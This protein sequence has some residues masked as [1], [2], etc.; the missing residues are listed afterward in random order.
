MTAF[1]QCLSQFPSKFFQKKL[2]EELVLRFYMVNMVNFA[3][4]CKSHQ[5]FQ[6]FGCDL[7]I[8]R[9]QTI[10][11]CLPVEITQKQCRDFPYLIGSYTVSKL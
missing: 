11:I 6:A 8:L 10:L 3:C 4:L 9:Q 1:E 2:L 5:R 7:N